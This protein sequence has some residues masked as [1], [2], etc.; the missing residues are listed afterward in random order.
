DPQTQTIWVKRSALGDPKTLL[1]TLF[2]ETLHKVSGAPDCTEGF[3]LAWEDLVVSLVM[4]QG[5]APRVC[6]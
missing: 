6:A 4:R 2:H 3:E 1:G 5:R